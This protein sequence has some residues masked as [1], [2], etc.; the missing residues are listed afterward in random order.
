[1][2]PFTI[3]PQVKQPLYQQLYRHLVTEITTG[4]LKEGEKLPSKR[5]LAAHLHISQTTIENAYT[6]LVT[7]GYVASRPRSGYYVAQLE[8]PV[9]PSQTSVCSYS[10]PTPKE[11]TKVLYPYHLRTNVVD[12]T[13]FPY[14]T[15]AKIHKEVLYHHKE[16]LNHGDVQGDAELREA[17]CKYLH[18][19]RGVNCDADQMVIG[20]G[21]EYLTGLLCMLLQDGI[22]ALE[23][24]GYPKVHQVITNHG[25]PVI[26]LPVGKH[27]MDTDALAQSDATIAYVTPSHQFPTGVTMPIATRMKLLAWAHSGAQRYIIEDDYD[28]EFRYLGRP[29]PCLQGL[30]TQHKVI[31]L[32]TF[33]RSLAPS[34]RIAY[35]ILPRPLLEQY[36]RTFSLFSSTVS[37][38]EQHTLAHF[39]EQG[40]YTR[41]LNRVRN[42]YRKRKEFIV[43]AL[44]TLPFSDHLEIQGENAGLHFLLT[45]H[46]L[47]SEA[48]LI[49]KAR[50]VGIH[51]HGLSEYKMDAGAPREATLVIGYSG[52]TESEIEQAVALLSKAWQKDGQ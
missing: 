10:T 48:Q 9:R 27:G 24:P 4:R 36:R 17:L 13:L 47:G 29:I 19:Y 39:I 30:D 37:R 31:Y 8:Q 5:E 45:V 41:H 49:E 2:N 34:I 25:R 38:F 15:W 11:Q 28:S 6:M 52:M 50:S 1:M 44:R 40:Q 16:L 26:R 18:E 33:S 7:E 46:G 51:L 35:M 12:T 32:G 22:F 3:N 43:S 14:T 21:L 23:N 42:L 20:A